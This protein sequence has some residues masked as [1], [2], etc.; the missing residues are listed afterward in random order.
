[1]PLL[2][3][4]SSGLFYETRRGPGV[5]GVPRVPGCPPWVAWVARVAWVAGCRV[6][7]LG[8][9]G[10]LIKTLMRLVKFSHRAVITSTAK[11]RNMN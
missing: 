7:G 8:V 10:S 3:A 4:T 9:P 6:A 5:P 11:L 1:M 2:V